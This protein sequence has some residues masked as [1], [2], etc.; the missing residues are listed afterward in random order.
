MSL[1]KK[2]YFCLT[3]APGFC[4]R[5]GQTE[6]GIFAAEC[7]GERITPTLSSNIQNSRKKGEKYEKKGRRKL[8]GSRKNCIVNK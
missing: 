4:L 7:G 8:G 6:E 3:V 5:I 1:L 2:P